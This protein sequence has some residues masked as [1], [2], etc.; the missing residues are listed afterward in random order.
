MPGPPPSLN[1]NTNADPRT[2]IRKGTA[3]GNWTW[4]RDNP[5]EAGGQEGLKPLVEVSGSFLWCVVRCE[6]TVT[7]GSQHGFQ[8][9]KVSPSS[10]D[11]QACVQKLSV[12]FSY[13]FQH[14]CVPGTP[15]LDCL[16]VL[17]L[18]GGENRD[19]GYSRGNC[20]KGTVS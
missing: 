4:A 20:N 2:G 5:R 19:G 6:R 8:A 3:V 16:L 14:V 10:R 7:E 13:F 1:D 9:G 12:K 18:L 15:F 11:D 17:K